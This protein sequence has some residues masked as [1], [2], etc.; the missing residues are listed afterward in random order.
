MKR[1]LLI[2]LALT[3]GMSIAPARAE[4]HLFRIDQVFS[5]ADGT[6]QYVVMLESSGSNGEG[7][8]RNIK[9]ATTSLAGARQ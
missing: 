4:F 3:L 9:L 8:W 5:N 7:F 6:I 2:A 1:F